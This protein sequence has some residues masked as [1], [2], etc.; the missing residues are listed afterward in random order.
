MELWWVWVGLGRLTARFR[1]LALGSPTMCLGTRE[2]SRPGQGARQGEGQGK[3]PRRRAGGGAGLSKRREGRRASLPLPFRTPVS[4]CGS[5]R[6]GRAAVSVE[7]SQHERANAMPGHLG[8]LGR[9]SRNAISLRCHRAGRRSRS[10]RRGGSSRRSRSSSDRS[11]GRGRRGDTAAAT[12]EERDDG[13]DV[14]RVSVSISSVTVLQAGGRDVDGGGG[15]ASAEGKAGRAREGERASGVKR[16]GGRGRGM[17]R[18]VGDSER[19]G[20]PRS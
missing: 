20:F 2:G 17:P 14:C 4:L 6:Y 11:G 5:P 9:T 3:G 7:R 16:C 15:P 18:E 10:G 8:C 1:P 19:V 12:A 13:T